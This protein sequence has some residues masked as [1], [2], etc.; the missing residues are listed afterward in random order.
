M[1][2]EC[3]AV[4]VCVELF[5]LLLCDLFILL[6][7]IICDLILTL[8]IELRNSSLVSMLLPVTADIKNDLKF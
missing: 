6:Q 2:T 7:P 1:N 4:I 8:I 5:T 3:I